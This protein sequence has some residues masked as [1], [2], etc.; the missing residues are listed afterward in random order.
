MKQLKRSLSLVLALVMLMSLIYVAPKAE[1]ANASSYISTSYAANLSVKT[2]AATGLRELPTTSSSAKYTLPTNTML[3]VKALHKGTDSR[4]WYEV[5]FYDMTLYVDATATTKVSHLTGD[6]SIDSVMSPASLY[7]GQSFGIEGDITSSLNDLGTITVSMHTS[8]N[9][10]RAPSVIASAKA[11]GKSYSL[12]GSSID[13][14][15]SFN[16]MSAGIYTYVVTAEAVSYYINDNDAL[17]TSTQDVVLE[18][19]QCVITDWRNPNEELAFGIDV[20]VWNGSIDW[21]KT[22]NVVDFVILRLGFSETLDNRFLEYATN[23]EKYD[24]PYG[25][26]HYSYALSATDAKDEANFVINTLE[27]NGYYPELGVWFDMEDSS[28]ASLGNSTKESLVTNFCDTIAAAGYEPGFYGFTSWFTT[29]FQNTYLSSIPVWIAQIDGFSSNGT[30]THDGG[31]WLWQYSWEGSISGISGDVDC[32]YA[33]CEFRDF[34]SDTTYLSKCT[35]YAAHSTGKVTSSVTIR[36]YPSTSYSSL[37]TI[38]TG[39]T[40]EITGVYKNTAGEYWYQVKSGS[41]YGYVLSSYVTVTDFLYNDIAVTAPTMADNLAVGKGYYLE[42]NLVSR[43]NDIGTAYAKVYSGED[44]LASPVLTSSDTCGSNSYKLKSSTV[45]DNMIFSNLSTGYYTYEISADVKNYYVSNGT[46]T[47]KTENVV[48]WTAP[49]TVGNATIT[50]P[51]QMVCSHNIVTD[52]AVPAT[53][54]TS[55]LTAGTHCSKCNVVLTAQTVTPATGHSYTATSE[56][57]N[58]QNYQKFHYSCIKCGNSYDISA[59]DLANWSDVKPIGVPSNQIQSKTQYRYADC[60]S[61]TWQEIGTN[62]IK[63]VPTWPSGFDTTDSTYAQYNKADSKVTETVTATTKTVINSDSKIGYLWYHWCSTS[64][65]S[66]WAYEYDTYTNF[67]VYYDTTDPSNY[68][69]DT[70][71]YSYKTSHSSCSN[72]NWWFPVEVYSQNYTTYKAVPDGQTWGAWSA[73]S[74]SVYTAIANSRKVETRTVY[75]YTGAT[76]GDHVWNNGTC[77]V[78]GTTCNHTFSNGICSVCGMDEPN[79]DYY[80]FGY[81]NGADYACE[82][83]FE[84]IGIYLFVD[85]KLT[86]KFSQPSYVA[87]KTGDNGKWFMTNGWQ[88]EVSSVTLYNTSITGNSSDKMYVPGNVEVTFTLVENSDGSLTLSYT[89]G[90]CSHSKHDTTGTCTSCGEAVSHTYVN[91]VCSVCGKTLTLPTLSPNYPTVSFEGAIELN[92]YYTATDLGSVDLSD[93][94]LIVFNSAQPDGTIA[95]ASDVIPGAT[96]SGGKYIVHTNGIAAKNLGDTLY[97]KVYARMDDGSYVYSK[98][99]STSPKNYALSIVKNTS[100]NSYIRSLCVSML[101]Y[102][103]EAQ[104]YFNYKSYDLMNASLT[105]DQKALVSAYD[106]SMMD[107]IVAV[108]GIK[109]AAFPR[110]TTAFTSMYPTVSFEGAFSINYY[111]VNGL[112]VDGNMTMYYWT[113]DTYNSVSQLTRTNAS[114]SFTMVNEGSR[115]WGEI[116][117]IPAKEMDDTIYV[118][119]VYTSGGTTYTTG[120]IAYSLGR[121]CEGIAGNSSNTAQALAAKTAVYGYYAE[122]YFDYLYG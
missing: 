117:N 72:S 45:C 25:V 116:A 4:W 81:I 53:C 121:Y 2:T 21:S 37:G 66:S 26:Y 82:A 40:L 115:Y 100:N 107:D 70:F 56:P 99:I 13:S 30:A 108:T 6:V 16:S 52:P 31:T 118:A 97:M 93:M 50:P 101:D 120:I 91:N 41:S 92:I 83:D 119:G 10:T 11:S 23:C 111:F 19:Q 94:G 63:Y 8:S 15:L 39:T 122:R 105:A 76:L 12:D 1:A 96:Q 68:S 71:D 112:T 103:A 60:T 78:C 88:G 65:T 102:G 47:S 59:N 55:G 58:C 34:S 18:K 5:L 36:Q 80:L 64:V 110:N 54:T 95:T 51:A 20:S 28:Q 86:T 24:I 73:W 48:L 85:G 3:A 22:K 27:S 114:G 61:T 32:N 74:D 79:K 75:R 29:T 35:H 109:G 62:S 38:S 67:H 89:T 46:L 87:V 69:C 113:A 17:A 90:Q 49:F 84:N 7:K 43:Y 42:G 14:S 106:G 44:T 9:I 98:M 57:A 77:T 33:Y 104:K